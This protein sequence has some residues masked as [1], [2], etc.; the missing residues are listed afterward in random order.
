MWEDHV[1][2]FVTLLSPLFPKEA[3]IRRCPPFSDMS[4][5]VDWPLNT[6]AARPHKRSC[7]VVIFLSRQFMEDYAE[8]D[9][10]NR[11]SEEQ[12]ITSRISARLRE[13][14]PNHDLPRSA[15]PPREVWKF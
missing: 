10:R 12:R 3:E 5:E 7:T 13:F 14:N 6:D 9:L 15:T 8:G 11:K 2:H 1:E 4:F